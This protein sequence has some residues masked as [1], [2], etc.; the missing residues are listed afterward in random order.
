MEE[1]GDEPIN[2]KKDDE[3]EYVHPKKGA[4]YYRHRPEALFEA[5]D[6]ATSS[7]EEEMKQESE[8]E[9]ASESDGWGPDF[10][11]KI[12]ERQ[13]ERK[14]RQDAKAARVE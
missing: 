9:A 3:Y 11:G 6:D 7:S 14:R 13:Q 5:D 12:Y 4:T 10:M 2:P 1:I 8:S